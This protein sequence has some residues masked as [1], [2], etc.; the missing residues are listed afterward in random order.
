MLDPFQMIVFERA[1]HVHGQTVSSNELSEFADV[2][3]GYNLKAM[4]M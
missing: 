1:A 3:T 4:R 2:L